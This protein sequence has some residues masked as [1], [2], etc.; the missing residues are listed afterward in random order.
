MVYPIESTIIGFIG[1]LGPVQLTLIIVPIILILLGLLGRWI[2]RDAK[3]RDS[4]WAWH[5]AFGIPVL[6]VLGAVPGLLALI[7]YLLMREDQR[8]SEGR[9]PSE[10]V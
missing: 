3:S 6:F 7:V 5:R 1:G 9:G 2:Y 8:S 10:T 4:E